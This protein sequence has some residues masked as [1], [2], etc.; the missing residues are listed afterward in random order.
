MLRRVLL[1]LVT[2]GNFYVFS[3]RICGSLFIN[4]LLEKMDTCTFGVGVLLFLFWILSIFD[5]ENL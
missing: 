4:T 2:F 1:R 3:S 5:L